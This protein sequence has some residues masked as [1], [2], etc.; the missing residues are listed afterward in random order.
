MEKK[1]TKKKLKPY[2]IFEIVFGITFAILWLV[3]MIVELAAPNSDFGVWVKNNVWDI[4]SIITWVKAQISVI[5][6]C[7]IIIVLVYAITRL[8]RFI[9]RARMKKSNR[10][11]TVITLFDGFIKYLCAILIIILVLK[12]CG[13]NT[14]ALIASVGVLTLVIGI[15]AQALIADI[16]AGI[17]IIFEN[18]YNV[19]E[20]V[21]IDGF[22]G[23]VVEIGIRST[24]IL[25][26][27]GNIKIINNSDIASVVNMSRELSLAVVDCE[28]PYDVPLEHIE[29]LFKDHLQ[30][31][32]EKI[33]EIVEGPFYKGVSNYGD[34]NVAVKIVAKCNEEDR[35][36][37]Q[38]DL[39]REYRLMLVE[40]GID[41]SFQQV[42]ISQA[43]PTEYKVNKKEKEEATKFVEEQ[44]EISADA[45][46]S[47]NV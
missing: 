17:F 9:F 21:S 14:T 3:C 28:F 44:K 34:S 6:G 32:G 43:V 36:Q 23:T 29:K 15:G 11:K 24:K 19:G 18:E 7:L 33:T 30:E 2:T 25:D 10:A 40:N 38:R 4:D 12:A 16:I 37:I 5:I 46:D 20:I 13:V 1:E 39:M 8:I 45:D 41:L 31:W 42:V 47:E 27:A 26:L 35:Y 22:R